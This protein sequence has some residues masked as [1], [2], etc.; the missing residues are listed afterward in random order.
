MRSSSQKRRRR[1]KDV[2][3]VVVAVVVVVVVVKKKNEPRTKTSVVLGRSKEQINLSQRAHV[4]ILG[5][6]LDLLD[7]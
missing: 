5:R 3:V 7:L 4:V 1:Q 2:V 6:I